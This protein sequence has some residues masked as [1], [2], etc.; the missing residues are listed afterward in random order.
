MMNPKRRQRLTL[1][2]F[3]LARVIMGLMEL[4]NMYGSHKARLK[5][6][7]SHVYSHTGFFLANLQRLS[8]FPAMILNL[9]PKMADNCMLSRDCKSGRVCEFWI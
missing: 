3:G 6:Q 7:I 5:R 4:G 8:G 2:I 1:H 9:P